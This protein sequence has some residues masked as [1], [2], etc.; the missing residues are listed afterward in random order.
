MCSLNDILYCSYTA[1][2]SNFGAD[3]NRPTG[4]AEAGKRVD[5]D[6]FESL[7]LL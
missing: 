1:V 7:G 5:G 3:E 2:Y 4:I 6:V